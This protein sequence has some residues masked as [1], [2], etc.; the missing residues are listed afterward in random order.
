MIYTNGCSFT[1]GDELSDN[2]K[3]WPYL[4]A[5]KMQ[6][7]VLNDAV[8]GG[9][10]YRSVY[11]TINHTRN[12]FDLY[13]IAWTTNTRYT[14]YKS[15]NN[16]EINFNPQL[17]N[18][19]YSDQAFYTKWGQDLYQHW[20][21]DLYATKIWL[22]QIIQLQALLE[23]NNKK[24][25]MI[26][27]FHNNLKNWLVKKEKFIQSVQSLINFDLMTDEQIFAEHQEI[28][29]Y[30]ECI[31]KETF[32]KWNDFAIC[33]IA[34]NYPTGP[35]GHILEDGHAYLADLIFQHIQCLK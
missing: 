12:Q 19:L 3:A 14:F 20:H 7:K 24:Y 30:V 27:T 25:L 34:E 35:G 23:K 15:D 10:N 21:N 2:A 4:L 6:T 1:F 16:F 26:N 11:Q 5:N 32:F 29:Y 17:K 13:V 18:D 8:S 33:D 9:T 31:N 22:Q 28:Q